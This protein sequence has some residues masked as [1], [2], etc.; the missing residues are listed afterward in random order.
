MPARDIY[1]STVR[2]ALEKTGWQVT[3]DPYLLKAGMITMYVDLGAERLLAADNGS[4]KIAVEVK[5]FLKASDLTEFHLAL[6]QFMNYKVALSKQEPDR[7]LYLAIPK[8][9]Y[10]SF[11]IQ[12]FIQEV[13]QQYQIKL[14]VFQPESEVITQW[15]N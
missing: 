1:H 2:H 9:T 15:L 3:A 7:V 6:G 10:D 11:F 14:I 4:N 5:C 8:D 13:L 12:P